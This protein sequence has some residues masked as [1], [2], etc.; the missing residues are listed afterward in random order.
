MILLFARGCNDVIITEVQ[1]ST[2]FYPSFLALLARTHFTMKSDRWVDQPSSSFSKIND[3]FF[4]R[5]KMTY[6]S[7]ETDNK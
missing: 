7:L 6:S 4:S 3:H 5:K 1:L 2:I